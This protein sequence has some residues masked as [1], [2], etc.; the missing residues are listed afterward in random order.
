MINALSVP[1]SNPSGGGYM[2]AEAGAGK[3][4]G[5]SGTITTFGPVEPH[6]PDCGKRLYFGM[7]K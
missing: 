2:Y 4:R 1:G 6:C 5:S 3:W 7:A